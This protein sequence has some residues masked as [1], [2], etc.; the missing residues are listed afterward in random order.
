MNPVNP[1]WV[2]EWY[3]ITLDTG[4]V[5]QARGEG[6]ATTLHTKGGVVGYEAA[7]VY[8]DGS[9]AYVIPGEHA[10]CRY[11]SDPETARREMAAAL[12]YY[13]LP[14]ALR[15]ELARIGDPGTFGAKHP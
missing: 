4:D 2:T 6:R 3:D 15:R 11:W 12:E 9:E 1:V 5:V 8:R 7:L 10:E 14:I 13:S